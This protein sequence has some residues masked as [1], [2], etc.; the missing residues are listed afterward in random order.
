MYAHSMRRNRLG[1][2]LRQLLRRRGKP[3][4]EEAMQ[5]L[6]GR[7][8][9]EEEVSESALRKMHEN[10]V[11]AKKF[12]IHS[13]NLREDLASMSSEHEDALHRHLS[14]GNFNVDGAG[15][16]ARGLL[17]CTNP[18]LFWSAD[19]YDLHYGIHMY[20]YIYICICRCRCICICIRVYIYI[21]LSLSIY[22]YICMYVCIYIYIYVYTC[23]YIY[24]YTCYT[25]VYIY[26]YTHM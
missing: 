3:D 23:V 26:I 6:L 21:S 9:V 22:I 4:A 8:L 5:Q 15:E 1:G 19:S 17:T 11:M 10:L 2:R 7:G 12:Y 20:I 14:D 24:I 25:C 18:T 13:L 16:T